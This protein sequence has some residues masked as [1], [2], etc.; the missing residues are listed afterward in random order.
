M[1][2]S[3][4]FKNI[5]TDFTSGKLD[6]FSNLAAT[7]LGNALAG[8][9][10]T[11]VGNALNTIGSL[12]SN[13]PGIG[14]LIGAGV[15]LTGGLVNAA[16]GSH[17]NKNFVNSENNLAAKQSG[18]TSNAGDN[19]SLLSDWD[20][21]NILSNVT[22]NQIGSDGWFSHKASHKA[23]SLNNAINDSNNRIISSLGNTAENISHEDYRKEHCGNGKYGSSGKQRTQFHFSSA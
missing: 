23:N 16:F 1:D 10:E 22:K 4:L 13:I 19:S 3:N 7:A 18:Y 11:G 17:I 14:G 5:G 2:F 6:G 9:N 21:M 15:N 20:N 8:K 12:A